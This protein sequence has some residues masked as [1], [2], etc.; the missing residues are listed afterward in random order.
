MS[1]RPRPVAGKDRRLPLSLYLV[2]LALNL[3]WQ[4]IMFRAHRPDLALVDSTGDLLLLLHGM[5]VRP[6]R[7]CHCCWAAWAGAAAL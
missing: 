3:V 7:F 4:P 5:P 2:Q 1:S 6:E